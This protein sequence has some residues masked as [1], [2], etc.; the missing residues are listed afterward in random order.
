MM[1]SAPIRIAFCITELDPGG[2]ERALV[3]LVTRLDPGQFEPVV[4]CLAKRGA[5]ADVLEQ[6]NVRVVCLGANWAWD[7]GVVFRLAKALR[8]FRP[9]ILQTWLYHANIIGR[10]AGRF[11]GVPIIVSGIRVAEKRAR[12]RLWAE[13]LT[14]F[15]VDAHVC[16]SRDVA[17][18]STTRGGL[19]S[20]RVRIIPNGVNFPRFANAEPADL[21]DLA[22]PRDAKILLCVG[23]LDPQ[24]DP[25]WLL[26]V[27]PALQK[28]IPAVQL[29]FVGQG[30]LEA[31]LKNAI[32]RENLASSAHL[33]GWRADVPQLLKAADVLVL[34]SRWE[35]MPNIVLEAL[36]SGTPVVSTEVE[37]IS[38]LV[39]PGE[40]GYIIPSRNTEAF[41]QALVELL[42]NPAI[43]DRIKKTAQTL[44]KE[45]FT[46]DTSCESYLDLYRQL[47]RDH[48]GIP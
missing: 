45:K 38:E 28:Q 35:G 4:F 24:K 47:L 1:F 2:A 7:V 12:R 17:T 9:A 18:F 46:W 20:S 5:L 34:P 10:F 23:R 42:Q 26:E 13:R 33:L 6:A 14:Q 37:G 29:V 43:G 32:D 41:V 36:A 15:L 30:P 25:L 27:F 19:K 22:L 3:E 31:A 11:A 8:K 40:T 39:I 44:V 21:S 48:P 16:V